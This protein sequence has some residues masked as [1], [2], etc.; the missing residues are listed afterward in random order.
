KH[1]FPQLYGK[2]EGMLSEECVGGFFPAGLKTKSGHLWFPTTKGVVVA[3]ARPASTSF[4]PPTVVLEEFL[5]DGA[6]QPVSDSATGL[7]SNEGT[8]G[9]QLPAIAPG[10]RD[11]EFRYT[12]L[13]LIA[14]E[15]IRF[16]YRLEGWE[17]DWVEAGARR[18]ATYGNLPAGQYRFRVAA[19][20]SDGVW[21]P[22]EAVVQF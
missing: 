20:N 6:I 11:M 17:A 18:L 21:N 16:R 3:D 9:D 1:S 19:C 2:P 8:H 4:P 14:P 12:G 5:V 13:S 7:T 15:R 22:L 10:K